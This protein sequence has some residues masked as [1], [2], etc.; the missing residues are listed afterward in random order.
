M[1][2]L[3]SSN[4]TLS[5]KI[6]SQSATGAYG[7]VMTVRGAIN[8]FGF[9]LLMVMAGAAFTWYQY[10]NQV[11]VLT[12]SQSVTPY[13]WGGVIGG[14]ICALAIIFK[15]TW[16]P[17]VAP[18]YAILEGLFLGA[19]SAIVN[20]AFEEKYPG[21]ILQAVGLTFG[22]AFAMFLL[23]NMRIIKATAKFRS[24][25]VSATAGI[26][27][28]YLI[29]LVLRLFNV[30]MP[31]MYDASPLGIGI[32]LFIIAIAALNLILDFDMI[33]RGADSGA[34]KFMEWYGAFGLLVTMIW[35]YLEILKLLVRIA[36]SRR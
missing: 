22:V 20:A 8:K 27:F 36:G 11:S 5:Q 6:F 15:P 18:A 33:E 35:L 21:L 3:E 34:P 1:A 16:S 14:L 13:L 7:E 32:S 17:Y 10:Y 31:F 30:N 29:T 19:I 9:L 4:P 28:F 12:A 25:I 26:F 2:L 24:I 23:Y